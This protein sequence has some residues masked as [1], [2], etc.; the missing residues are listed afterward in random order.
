MIKIRAKPRTVGSQRRNLELVKLKRMAFIEKLSFHLG[1][2]ISDY[3]PSWL[4]RKSFETIT[5]VAS[6]PSL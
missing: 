6:T 1:E 2:V 4:R 3:N 5:A